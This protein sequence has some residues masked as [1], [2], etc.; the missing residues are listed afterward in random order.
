MRRSRSAQYQISTGNLDPVPQE[1]S[2]VRNSGYESA[3]HGLLDKRGSSSDSASLK[4]LKRAD[5]RRTA[6]C[7]TYDTTTNQGQSPISDIALG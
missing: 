4:L 3:F 2:D 6:C 7:V 1:F 5:S